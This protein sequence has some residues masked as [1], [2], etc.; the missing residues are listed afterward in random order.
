MQIRRSSVVYLS[1]DSM[2]SSSQVNCT[3]THLRGRTLLIWKL[4]RMMEP[5]RVAALA[6]VVEGLILPRIASERVLKI[7][8][9]RRRERYDGVRCFWFQTQG[10][11]S[12]CRASI[13][14]P[15]SLRSQASRASSSMV[16]AMVALL[17]CAAFAP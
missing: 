8:G 5:S 15:S 1:Q 6:T 2:I 11:T 17:V 4:N 13:T 10:P 12:T 9:T 7:I 3:G 16:S 14:P